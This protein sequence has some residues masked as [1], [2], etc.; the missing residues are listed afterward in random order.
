[1][2]QINLSLALGLYQYK[3]HP[4]PI[5]QQNGRPAFFN[6]YFQQYDPVI[7]SKKKVL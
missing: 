1:M 6:E 2:C 5:Q 4:F 3:N 7:K